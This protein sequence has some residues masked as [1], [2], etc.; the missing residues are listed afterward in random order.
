MTFCTLLVRCITVILAQMAR[1]FLA[2]V[3]SSGNQT[4]FRREKVG[5]LCFEEEQP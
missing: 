2:V 5:E 4:C 3:S 1:S